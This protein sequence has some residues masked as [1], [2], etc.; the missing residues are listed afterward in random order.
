MTVLGKIL[1]ILNLVLSLAVGAFVVMTYVSRT[2]WHAAYKNMQDQVQVTKADALAYK[3]DMEQAKGEKAQLQEQ[4]D[5]Q[6][7]AAEKEQQ[8]LTAQINDFGEKLKR[9][10]EENARHI[11]AQ[12]AFDADLKRRAS[13]VEYLKQLVAA[14]DAQLS[15]KDLQVNHTF[16]KSTSSAVRTEPPCR[17]R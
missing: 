10:G 3:K 4:L 6:K 5:K 16:K 8:S 1:A 2:N 12:R 9:A 13:E 15:K 17:S 14:R 11:S 7:V